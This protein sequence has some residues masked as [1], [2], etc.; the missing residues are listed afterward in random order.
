MLLSQF[1]KQLVDQFSYATFDI[2]I[3]TKQEQVKTLRLEQIHGL[4]I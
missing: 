4:A 1:L 3:P 2:V